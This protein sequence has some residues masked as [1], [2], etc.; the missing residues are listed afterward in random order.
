MEDGPLQIRSFRVVFD[1]ERRIHRIDRYRV[2][3][4]YGLPLRSIGYAAAAFVAVLVLGR[5]PA[6]GGMLGALP[7]PAHYVLL[8][9]GA[10]YG[11]TQLRMDGRSA[12]GAAAAWLRF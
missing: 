7:P 3:L 2:P 12:H 10:S 5:L 6:V 11:L 4:P 8:P 1:L 9:V